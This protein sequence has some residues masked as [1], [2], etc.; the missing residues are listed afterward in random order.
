MVIGE[1]QRQ[2]KSLRVPAAIVFEPGKDI[3][4]LSELIKHAKTLE[5]AKLEQLVEVVGA[6]LHVGDQGQ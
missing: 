3:L 1:R 2:Y 5:T 4:G 6:E